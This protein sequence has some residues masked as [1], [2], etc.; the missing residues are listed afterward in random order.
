M[1]HESI[2]T[3]LRYAQVTSQKAESAARHAFDV[4]INTEN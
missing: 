1:G 3:T 4:L 2:Q